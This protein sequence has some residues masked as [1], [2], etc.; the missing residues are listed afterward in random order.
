LTF[1]FLTPIFSSLTSKS[2]S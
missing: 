2:C 1:N